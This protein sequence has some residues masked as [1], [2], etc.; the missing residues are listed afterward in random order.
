LIKLK[1]VKEREILK[2]ATSPMKKLLKA[3]VL[4]VLSELIV[5]N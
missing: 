5:P 4:M 3:I 1:K 2:T